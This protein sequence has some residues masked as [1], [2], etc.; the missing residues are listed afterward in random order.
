MHPDDEI[1]VTMT[2]ADFDLL[3]ATLGYAFHTVRNEPNGV[4]KAEVIMKLTDRI[5]HTAE[6]LTLA[7][8]D[9]KLAE[10]P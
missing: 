2:Q 6:T 3:R 1:V 8:L 5:R 4:P 7:W 10:F 9:K